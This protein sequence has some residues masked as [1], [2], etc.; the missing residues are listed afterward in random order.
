MTTEAQNIRKAA[1]RILEPGAW[2]QKTTA[3][4]ASGGSV[5]P[6]S[7][8]ACQ[9]CAVG[10]LYRESA[11]GWHVEGRVSEDYLSSLNDRPDTK[12]EDMATLLLLAAE[13][14]ESAS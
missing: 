10:A 4:D 12:A 11:N 14:M 1:Y 5:G 2:I 3:R 7:P 9:W 13:I 6:T 8:D